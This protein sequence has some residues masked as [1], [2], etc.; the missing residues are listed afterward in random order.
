MIKELRTSQLLDYRKML[1]SILSGIDSALA[2]RSRLIEYDS[3]TS[4]EIDKSDSLNDPEPFYHI[5][6]FDKGVSIVRLYDSKQWF[7]SDPDKCYFHFTIRVYNFVP[8]DT[9]KL[10]F[11]RYRSHVDIGDFLSLDDC[12]KYFSKIVF[13]LLQTVCKLSP[14]LDLEIF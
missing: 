14:C 13:Q 10:Q 6:L 5:K 3:I 12:L 4:L 7:A 11:K 9:Y 2:H 1:N 8:Y